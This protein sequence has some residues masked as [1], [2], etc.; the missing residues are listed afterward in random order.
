[1]RKQHIR[2]RHDFHLMLT[3]DVRIV[4]SAQVLHIRF[5][6]YAHP[7]DTVETF[8]RNR[9]TVNDVYTSVGVK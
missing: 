6:V 8:Q 4:N 3:R 9:G 1:M 7:F 5:I 2:D